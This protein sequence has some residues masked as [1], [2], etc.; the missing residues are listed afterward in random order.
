M[1]YYYD[2]LTFVSPFYILFSF[3]KCV[4]RNRSLLDSASAIP[5][6]I[7]IMKH[8][9]NVDNVHRSTNAITCR[10]PLFNGL[11]ISKNSEF[12][13]ENS[14]EV[15]PREHVGIGRIGREAR[16]AYGLPLAQSV[17]RYIKFIISVLQGHLRCN[18]SSNFECPCVIICLSYGIYIYWV[19]S[20]KA[21]CR[22]IISILMH[23]QQRI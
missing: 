6:C 10:V 17:E 14:M 5:S 12:L 18:S 23:F 11:F 9:K 15:S 3:S 1:N 7:K 22:R 8:N 20:K 19:S 4:P 2:D 21:K 16:V 13:V